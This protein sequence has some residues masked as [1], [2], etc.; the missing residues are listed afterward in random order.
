MQPADRVIPRQKP[1]AP[2]GW[3]GFADW[4][5]FLIFGISAFVFPPFAPLRGIRFVCLAVKKR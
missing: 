4:L 5:P 3:P 1:A 2:K